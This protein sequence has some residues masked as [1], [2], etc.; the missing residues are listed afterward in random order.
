MKSLDKEV[1]FEPFE[2]LFG[3]EDGL[4]YYRKIIS[5]YKDKLKKGGVLAFEL[6]YNQ[7][8]SVI[9]L[10]KQNGFTQ[11]YEQKDLSGIRRAVCAVKE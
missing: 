6:G 1:L 10:F 9:E 3:G 2:A 5:V 11:I 4:E 7:A 8:D